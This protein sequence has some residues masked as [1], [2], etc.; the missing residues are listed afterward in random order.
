MWSQQD[1]TKTKQVCNIHDL[2]IFNQSWNCLKEYETSTS[3]TQRS[4]QSCLGYISVPIL[5]IQHS[6]G[7]WG[8]DLKSAFLVKCQ[9]QAFFFNKR[10]AKVYCYA[11]LHVL[12][13]YMHKTWRKNVKRSFMR[14]GR[15]AG[16]ARVP[17]RHGKMPWLEPWLH[18][19][20]FNQSETHVARINLRL[21]VHNR[22][23]WLYLF[24][25]NMTWWWNTFFP[26]VN[27]WSSSLDTF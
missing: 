6:S 1:K 11:F 12:K 15:P 23:H 16:G 2:M 17:A 18:A 26:R 25:P 9:K 5:K 10:E 13:R 8:W 4:Q 19:V 20:N 3:S 22:Q 21:E 27:G 7:S 14:A 24:F